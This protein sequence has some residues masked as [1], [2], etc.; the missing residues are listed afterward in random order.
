[1]FVSTPNSKVHSV[2]HDVARIQLLDCPDVSLYATSSIVSIISVRQDPL[3]VTPVSSEYVWN[4]IFFS[5]FRIKTYY[6]TFAISALIPNFLF[7]KLPF[8]QSVASF[9]PLLLEILNCPCQILMMILTCWAAF[10][11]VRKAEFSKNSG[12]KFLNK[13]LGY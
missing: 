5:H 8:F 3:T 12:D 1:M 7:T 10:E 13:I 2:P 6:K 4:W 9:L 11:L